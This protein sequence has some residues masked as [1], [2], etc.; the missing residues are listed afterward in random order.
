MPDAHRLGSG[1][2]SLSCASQDA[3]DVNADPAELLDVDGSDEPGADH[4]G[5][6]VGERG[7]PSPAGGGDPTTKCLDDL[8]RA[9]IVCTAPDAVKTPAV[10][11]NAALSLNRPQ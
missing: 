1:R 2:A 5:T 8:E 4:G 6:D 3:P 9:W 7:H 10:T 11:G